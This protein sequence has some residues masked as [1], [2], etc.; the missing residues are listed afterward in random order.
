MRD[1]GRFER[2]HKLK[3]AAERQLREKTAEAKHLSAQLD[4]ASR[5][6]KLASE[7]EERTVKSLEKSMLQTHEL[8]I[9]QASLKQ[10]VRELQLQQSKEDVKQEVKELQQSK[11]DA[12]REAQEL[13]A[14]QADLKNELEKTQQKLE[15]LQGHLQE[16]RAERDSAMEKKVKYKKE[17]KVK[18]YIQLGTSTTV[19]GNI[20]AP[21]PLNFTFI[22]DL[23]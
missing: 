9:Q 17:L 19:L 2:L 10:E 22:E 8:K 4:Q 16:A 6:A 18:L 11:E 1:G 14:Q 12:E 7:R 15:K 20:K 3:E 23:Q 5:D 13:K 21:P